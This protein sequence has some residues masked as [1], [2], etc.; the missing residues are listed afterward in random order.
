MP[1][2]VM[3]EGA[4]HRLAAAAAV[5]HHRGLGRRL[6]GFGPFVGVGGGAAG[7]GGGAGGGGRTMSS[8][9]VRR[10]EEVRG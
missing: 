8:S 7:E 6:S 1:K 9:D 4:E 10:E 5:G 2:Y 3:P